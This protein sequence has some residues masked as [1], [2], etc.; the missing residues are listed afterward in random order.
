M[1]KVLITIY[2]LIAFLIPTNLFAQCCGSDF[3][4]AKL[5]QSGVN[6][7]YGTQFYV[8]SGFNNYID[9]YNQKY[10]ASLNS[11]IDEF[12]TALG[13]KIGANLVQFQLDEFSLAFKINYQQMKE[14]KSATRSLAIGGNAKEEFNLT[15]TS[16]GLGLSSSLVVSKRFDIKFIDA[17]LTWNSAKLV[18]TYSDLLT[19]GEQTLQSP[20]KNMG[21]SIG[22]G[23]TF[24]IVPSYVSLEA[25][26]GYSLFSITRMQF[27]EGELL[28]QTPDG[29][30]AMENFIKSG[31]FY[32]FIQL[33]FSVPFK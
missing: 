31:G 3:I 18:N 5:V 17:L 13:F 30:P 1:R 11:K 21:F 28:S 7:G 8:P 32:T 16:F 10:S 22:V 6:V 24:Y 15:L 25:T 26:A 19:S 23:L 29:G 14:K 4:A 9:L 20:K 12:G 27:D 2:L 33:N